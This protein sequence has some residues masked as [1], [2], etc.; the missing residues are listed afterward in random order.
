MQ[1]NHYANLVEP[2]NELVSLLWIVDQTFHCT[3]KRTLL[4]LGDLYDIAPYLIWLGGV[5]T[6]AL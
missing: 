6:L 5:H 1:K 2:K 3:N 4:L